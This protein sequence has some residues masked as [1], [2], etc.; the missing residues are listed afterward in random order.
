MDFYDIASKERKKDGAIMY[1]PNFHYRRPTDLLV[2]GHRFVAVWDDAANLWSTNEW[3]LVRLIDGDISAYV[4]ELNEATGS[5][6]SALLME[7]HASGVMNQYAQFLKNIPDNW[8]PL[9]EKLTFENSEVSKGDYATKRL[10]YSL[11]EGDCSAWNAIIGTL[12]EPE[13]REKIEW[14]IGSIIAGE[15]KTI[16]KFFVF[17]GAPGTGKSTILLVLEQL[18][19]G[20]TTVFDA[21]ALGSNNGQFATAAFKNNP[22]VA[23]QHDGD[24]SKITDNTVLNSLVSHEMMPINEKFQAA[25][26]AKSNA[27]IFMAT[28]QPVM[29]TDSR[30]GILRRLVDI[31]PSGHTIEHDIFEALRERIPRELGAIAYHC[32]QVY[33][34]GGRKR[35]DGYRPEAMMR[36]TDPFYNF[37]QENFDIFKRE[38]GISL[39]RAWQMYKEYCEES[40]LRTMKKMDV[41]R[42]LEDYFEEF[43]D[44]HTDDDGKRVRNYFRGFKHLQTEEPIDDIELPEEEEYVVELNRHASIFDDEN[45]NLPAQYTSEDGTR[46]AHKWDN[47]DTTLGDLDTSQEHYVQIPRQHI[48]IDF[49]LKDDLGNKSLEAN[50]EAASKWPPTYAEISKGGNGIHLHYDYVG[51]VD[52]LDSEFAPNIEVKTLLGK[53]SLRRKLTMCNDLP[54]S[55]MTGGL[56]TKETKMLDNR[57]IKSEKGVR[58]LIIRNLRKDIHPGTRPSVDFIKKILDEAYASGLPYD[59][60]DMRSDILTFASLSSNHASECMAMVKE[61]KFA[62]ESEM[63]ETAQDD[64]SIVFYDVEVYPNLFVVCWKREGEESVQRMV[65]PTA[66]DLEPLLSQKLVGFNNRRYDNHILYARYIGYTVEELYH[67]SSKIVSSGNNRDVLFKEA[68]NLSYTD[69][70]DFSSKKQGLKKFQIELGIFHMEMD[71]PWD[72]PVPE[73]LWEKVQDYCVNDVIATE[74]V[75]NA[76]KQD[77]VARQILADLSGLTVNQSTLSHTAKIIFGN[78]RHPQDKFIYTELGDELFPGY[79]FDGKKSTYKGIEVGEGGYVYAEPGIYEDVALLDIASMH[80]TSIE[81]LDLFGPYTVNF[82]D[83]KTARLAIKRKD[84]EQAG[85]VL[86]GK[87]KPYLSGSEEDAEAL[88]YALKIVINIVYGLTSARFDNPFKDWRNKDNI[89][90]KRGALFMVDLKE[91]VQGQGFTVAHIKTDSIKIPGA[92]P[93]IIEFVSDFG[94]KYGYEF[95]HEATYDKLC[96]VNDAVYIARYDDKWTA[97]GAQF[98]HPYV[99]STLFDKQ[100]I[101]FDDLC[102]AKS[103]LQGSIFIDFQGDGKLENMRH[104]GRNGVFVPVLSGGGTLY[105][106][107]EDKAYAVTGT[108]GHK[109]M[110]SVVAKTKYDEGTLEVDYS[111]FEKLVEKAMDNINEYGSYEELIQ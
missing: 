44:H 98:Q 15:S 101:E 29:I 20:Y 66:D 93:E 31:N 90:A 16:Q 89:V 88:S 22:L 61:M 23:I 46:P 69:I 54:I 48:V 13:E 43:L 25:Y 58:D 11:E 92:T 3:D 67:L 4:R 39:A 63:P 6:A 71:I 53:A 109:W 5:D 99:F 51:N 60:T 80:P 86:G 12:Y 35:Y 45:P 68:Y 28:N 2:R 14:A 94:A 1:F 76:R 38:D 91:A 75:F 65:N 40:Q 97:V 107:K 32:L 59:V 52:E 77:F 34:K 7:D 42:Q 83:L 78:D 17:Y 100:Q 87:L 106:V 64:G 56:P 79:E 18:F 26:H 84:F 30:S 111:Y 41:K 105:R 27:T 95:E 96:L 73:D 37:I 85:E 8:V 70:Y 110:E 102:E 33:R 108:K 72:E 81:L 104:V 24:L 36:H 19:Q 103:V 74:A 21:K 62:S 47:V 9:D 10:P 50:L 55:V 49:D 57:S 82:S